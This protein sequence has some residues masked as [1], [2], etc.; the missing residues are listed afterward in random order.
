MFYF[1]IL[2]FFQ[3]S[4]FLFLLIVITASISAAALL[5]SV[6]YIQSIGSG[7]DIYSELFLSALPLVKPRD[8]KPSSYL[9]K[10]ERAA[11][12]VRKELKDI[13]VGLL[14][15]DLFIFK[16]KSAL[17]VSLC[18]SQGLVHKEYLEHLY[19]LFK[20]YCLSAPKITDQL[21]H[22]ITGKVYSCI[23]FQTRALPCFNYYYDLFYLEGKK[24]VPSNIADLLTEA[25]LAYWICDDGSPHANG[26]LRLCTNSFT[27]QDVTRLRD[28]L[29]S[30][31]GLT[32]TIYKI[33]TD[34]YGIYITK[35]SMDKVRSIV[36]QHMAPSMLYKIHL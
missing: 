32:C 36:K 34:R 35:G 23:R 4:S 19:D 28:V 18:F 8:G 20:S 2:S 3:L 29:V 15:G 13:I 7:I 17:N 21:P 14:L 24:V 11:F 31:F 9:T 5:I 22:K 10:E 27:I 1:T 26:G 16:Q 25:S 6:V 30:R 33:Q 12:S